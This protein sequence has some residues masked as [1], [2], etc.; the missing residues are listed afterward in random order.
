[1]AKFYGTLDSMNGRAV[2]TKTGGKDGIKAAAQSYDG[3]VITRIYYEGDTLMVNLQ[4]S[5]C[6]STSGAIIFEGSVEELKAKLRQFL[7]KLLLY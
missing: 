5:N 4:V 2:A 1:M 6:S 7:N 3:S